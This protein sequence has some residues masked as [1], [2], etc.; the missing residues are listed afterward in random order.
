MQY[1]TAAFCIQMYRL[2]K[3]DMPEN[4]SKRVLVSNS[5]YFCK[6][7]ITLVG[8]LNSE[9]SVNVM[10]TLKKMKCELVAR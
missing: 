8:K 9:Q 1:F 5:C 4:I 2:P 6:V 3:L 10:G 7:N